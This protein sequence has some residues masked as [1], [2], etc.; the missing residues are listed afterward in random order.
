MCVRAAYSQ[1][2]GELKGRNGLGLR[3]NRDSEQLICIR[4][5]ARNCAKL[6]RQG[7]DVKRAA[8]DTA[9]LLALLRVGVA[10][11]FLV[12][13]T[14][15]FFNHSREVADFRRWG[16]PLTPNSVYLIGAIELG[17]GLLLLTALATRPAALVL[18]GDMIGALATAGRVD[19]GSQLVIP[20]LLALALLTLA[21]FGGGRW[22]LS[23]RIANATDRRFLLLAHRMLRLAQTLWVVCG[24]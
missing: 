11:V 1:C 7:L 21:R 19:G 2:G 18:T 23:A 4:R 13:G 10:L 15:H 22:P 3:G 5:P 14:S 16:V 6:W 12:V 20:P 8:T 17:F 24:G 9:L